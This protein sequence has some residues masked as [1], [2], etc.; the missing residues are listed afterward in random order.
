MAPN[1][2]GMGYA[3][4]AVQ[5]VHAWGDCY[6]SAAKTF[7][8]IIK[9]NAPSMRL[10]QEAGYRIEGEA[11]FLGQAAYALE[12]AVNNRIAT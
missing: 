2:Q 7:C 1:K 4:E 11:V 12:R 3:S 6:L 8:V 9:T 10:A 5:A